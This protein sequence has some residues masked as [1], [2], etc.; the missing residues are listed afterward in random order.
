REWLKHL[1]GHLEFAR[2]DPLPLDHPFFSWARHVRI[3]GEDGQLKVDAKPGRGS[4]DPHYCIAL[5]ALSY[6]LNG[7]DKIRLFKPMLHS[8]YELLGRLDT[9]IKFTIRATLKL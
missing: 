3:I 9:L 7:L 8:F 2:G 1:C 6:K 5:S 4:K